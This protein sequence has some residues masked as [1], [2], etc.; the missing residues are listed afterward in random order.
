MSNL[1]PDDKKD[2]LKY[3]GM[4]GKYKQKNLQVLFGDVTG[5]EISTT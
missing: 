5:T 2:Q 4:F 3:G 1:P